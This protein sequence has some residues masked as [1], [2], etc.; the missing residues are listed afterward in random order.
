LDDA[1][2]CKVVLAGVAMTGCT[3][4]YA[5]VLRTIM[6]RSYLGS[7]ASGLDRTKSPARENKEN[8]YGL[9]QAQAL[10]EPVHWA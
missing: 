1:S 9:V 2:C 7:I 10:P 4:V 3:D 6:L 5:E 8:R